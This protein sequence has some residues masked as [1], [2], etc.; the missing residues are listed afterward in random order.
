MYHEQSSINVR[1][2]ELT[3]FTICHSS[4]NVLRDVPFTPSS[5]AGNHTSPGLHHQGLWTRQIACMIRKHMTRLVVNF[6]TIHNYNIISII[7]MSNSSNDSGFVSVS[8]EQEELARHEWFCGDLPPEEVKC[9]LLED[10]RE[11]CFVVTNSTSDAAI[12][13]LSIYFWA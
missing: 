10:G 1:E 5:V 4:N 7:Q 6:V 8:N 12:F 3:Q 2:S 11:G 13:N 9:L